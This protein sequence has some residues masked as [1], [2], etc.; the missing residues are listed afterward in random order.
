M[1]LGPLLA[2]LRKHGVT[3]YSHDGLSITFGAQPAAPVKAQKG[4]KEEAKP[5][6]L[7]TDAVELALKLGTR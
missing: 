1:R 3:S 6:P 5:E 7:P 4:E 2:L